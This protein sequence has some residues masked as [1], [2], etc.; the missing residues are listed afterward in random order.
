MINIKN[1]ILTPLE[2]SLM[3]LF[4]AKTDKELN[5]LD[6]RKRGILHPTKVI[7]SLRKKGAIIEV[8]RKYHK[9]IFQTGY[10]CLG[11]YTY[12]GWGDE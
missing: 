12:K 4:I 9:P 6:L 7:C 3:E 5:T 8:K 11:H 10:K 2:E 1:V